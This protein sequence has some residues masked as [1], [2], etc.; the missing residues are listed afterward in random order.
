LLTRTYPEFVSAWEN[1]RYDSRM[2]YLELRSGSHTEFRVPRN[3]HAYSLEIKIEVHGS[4]LANAGEF[5]AFTEGLPGAPDSVV[6]TGDTLLTLIFHSDGIK[7]PGRYLQLTR[8]GFGAPALIHS[9]SLFFNSVRVKE[10][11]PDVRCPF[12]GTELSYTTLILHND[13]S[14]LLDRELSFDL[15]TQG[16]DA[17]TLWG[18]PSRPAVYKIAVLGEHVQK[19]RLSYFDT[20]KLTLSS[21]EVSLELIRAEL[22]KEIMLR[23][24]YDFG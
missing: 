15:T 10:F 8:D 5:S 19:L 13:T 6:S 22:P 7:L 21:G 16:C 4:G 18:H 9:F 20:T 14:L 24:D 17:L 2:T 11:T 1:L 3:F 23:V 12:V